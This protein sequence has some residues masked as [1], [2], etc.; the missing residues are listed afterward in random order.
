MVLTKPRLWAPTSEWS[1]EWELLETELIFRVNSER[2][3]RE[4]ILAMGR[5][6]N[7]EKDI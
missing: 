1:P 4:L 3:N 2:V 7:L 6:T 5:L